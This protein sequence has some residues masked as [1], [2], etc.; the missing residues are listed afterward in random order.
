[1]NR[2]ELESE[3]RVEAEK[4]NDGIHVTVGCFQHNVSDAGHDLRVARAEVK[5]E[6]GVEGVCLRILG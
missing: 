5:I 6:S 1:M 4:I 2:I 3:V